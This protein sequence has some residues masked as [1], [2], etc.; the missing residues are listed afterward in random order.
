MTKLPSCL[1]LY[2]FHIFIS[3]IFQ[4]NTNILYISRIL[5]FQCDKE[6]IIIKQLPFKLF[7][8][9]PKIYSALNNNHNNC[10]FNLT[11]T[12]TNFNIFPPKTCRSSKTFCHVKYGVGENVPQF[13]QS[14]FYCL[15]G[16]A[17]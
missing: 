8:R 15:R 7:L 3:S 16:A 14:A 1:S 12:F 9:F 11:L 13:N 4:L 17:C 2:Q 6:Q 10:A 5:T